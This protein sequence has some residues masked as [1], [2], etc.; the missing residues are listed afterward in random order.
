[1][2]LTSTRDLVGLGVGSRRHDC[3]EKQ[4]RWSS[5]GEIDVVDEMF[6]VTTAIEFEARSKSLAR[7]M[8]NVG[9]SLGNFDASET[10]L[11]DH[12]SDQQISR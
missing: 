12:T 5:L 11:A 9:L 3:D 1:L 2:A 6:V 10:A 8:K 4:S 7:T